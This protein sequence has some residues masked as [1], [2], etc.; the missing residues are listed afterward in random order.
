M[1]G[2]VVKPVGK[3]HES[4]SEAGHIFLFMRS[5]IQETAPPRALITIQ[6]T[7]ELRS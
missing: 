5:M 7:T 4:H 3:L 2:A 1:S 6:L